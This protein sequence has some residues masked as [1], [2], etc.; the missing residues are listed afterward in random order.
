M[1]QKNNNVNTKII[2]TTK[3]QLKNYYQEKLQIKIRMLMIKKTRL[4]K[5]KTKM[6]N[7]NNNQYHTK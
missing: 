4:N 1:I 3:P 5:I 6:N 7:K 2:F